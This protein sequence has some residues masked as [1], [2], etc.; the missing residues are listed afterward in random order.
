[1]PAIP[2]G[3][4]KHDRAD[5]L[6]TV[7]VDP[8]SPTYSTVIHRLEVAKG[9]E[10]H[11]SGWNACSSCHGDASK[12]RR[13]LILPGLISGN[14]TFVDVGTTAEENRKPKLHKVV[15]GSD[16]AA[17]TGLA[18]PHT[19]HCLGSGE[20]MA[21]FM[22]D[23]AGNA[24]G[25]FGLLDEDFNIKGRWER[26]GPTQFG[27]DFWYQPRHN[28]M[29][30]SEWGAPLAF[31]KGF[32]PADVA[33]GKYGRKLHVWDWTERKVIQE[34]D[35]GDKGWIPLELRF[36]HNPDKTEGFVGAALSSA[37]H[38]FYKEADGQWKTHPVIE[39][40]PQDVEG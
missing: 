37:V 34:I 20:I 29:I 27:Y 4:G 40:T 13:Y 5:Y 19:V 24:E 21:S 36:L 9:E 32:N 11:H 8:Q 14:F 1:V 25:G 35:L 6:A 15:K 28:V 30:S 31:T 38:R 3:E 2:T 22:G 18:F 12:Q 16:I 17:K 23:T 7:D 10:L 33:E 39:V 26:S